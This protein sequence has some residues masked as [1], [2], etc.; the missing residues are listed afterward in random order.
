M[1]AFKDDPVR[2]DVV[3]STE[4]DTAMSF[5]PA[6]GRFRKAVEFECK[7]QTVWIGRFG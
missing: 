3:S 2:S 6:R 1:H 7:K 4:R 5:K